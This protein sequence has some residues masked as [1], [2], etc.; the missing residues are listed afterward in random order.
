MNA[1]QIIKEQNHQAY[2]IP[3]SVESINFEFYLPVF[4][5]FRKNLNL[6]SLKSSVKIQFFT[7]AKGLSNI[8][9]Q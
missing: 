8:S 3:V 2:F 5:L 1:Q 6:K 4:F 7:S 9:V